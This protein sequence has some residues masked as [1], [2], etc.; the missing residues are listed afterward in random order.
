MFL[1]ALGSNVFLAVRSIVIERRQALAIRAID[2]SWLTTRE[3]EKLLRLERAALVTAIGDLP[4]F[5]PF[6]AGYAASDSQMINIEAPLDGL[7]Y[8]LS[9]TCPACRQNLPFLDSLA[10]TGTLK[11][12]G[13]AREATVEQ[14]RLYKERERTNLEIVADPM[15]YIEAITPRSVT[16]LSVIVF[17]GRVAAMV[18]GRLSERD[19]EEL[20]RQARAIVAVSSEPRPP[21]E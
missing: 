6:I 13:F 21:K 2:S 14:L 9:P 4:T 11:V 15:G 7:Y 16:P 3:S 8:L 20:I 5:A 10:A 12:L 17:R 18:N 19:K 1:V